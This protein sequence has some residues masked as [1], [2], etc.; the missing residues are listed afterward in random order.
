VVLNQILLL[1]YLF[2]YMVGAGKLGHG[3]TSRVY[4]PKVIEALTGTH[5]RKLVCSGQSSMA[6]T[7]AGQVL[8]TPLLL[9]MKILM[10]RKCYL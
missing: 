10:I 3:D 9:V 2:A 1:T 7:F 6:L 8:H 5:I 4:K